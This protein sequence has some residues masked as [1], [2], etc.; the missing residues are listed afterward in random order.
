MYSTCS[1]LKEENEDV[2]EKFFQKNKGFE[3]ITKQYFIS[4][5]ELAKVEGFIKYLKNDKYV[6]IMPSLEYDGF[7]ICKI[8]KLKED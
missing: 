7:F 5:K 4:K 8:R 3:I 2:I 1:I 6:E